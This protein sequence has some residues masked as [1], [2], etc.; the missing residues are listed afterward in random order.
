MKNVRKDK[1]QKYESGKMRQKR[2]EFFR[3]TKKREISQNKKQ[4]ISKNKNKE[5]PEKQKT[6][7]ILKNG[8][9]AKT[10]RK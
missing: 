6:E 9:D 10:N 1:I 7:N 5:Y 3:K 8:K 2:Q 4:G